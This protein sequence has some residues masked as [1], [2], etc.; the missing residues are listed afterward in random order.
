[1]E[2]SEYIYLTIV[3]AISLFPLGYA[4]Y[5]KVSN[6][7]FFITSIIGSVVVLHFLL[8]IMYLP[9]ALFLVKI[10]PEL[11]QQAHEAGENL[12]LVLLYFAHFNELV[13]TWWWQV[14]CAL[15]LL[16]LPIMLHRRY[17]IFHLTSDYGSKSS[18]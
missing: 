16:L 10:L 7:L 17:S 4:F 13:Q 2:I 8:W 1:M 9:F 18:F 6:K 15:S 14:L 5:K 11:A 12:N 3:I